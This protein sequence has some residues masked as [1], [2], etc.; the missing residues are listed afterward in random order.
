MTKILLIFLHARSDF[1]ALKQMVVAV[2]D[3]FELSANR[4]TTN[5]GAL[6]Y[7]Q[8]ECLV[9]KRAKTITTLT[10]GGQYMA[11]TYA[12]FYDVEY[13]VGQSKTNAST[14]VMLVQY[15]LFYGLVDPSW[16][17]PLGPWV[18]QS[19]GAGDIFPLDG[20]FKPG[21]EEWIKAF[22]TFANMNGLG[23]LFVDGFVSHGGAAWG[24]HKPKA[25]KWYT[26]HAMNHVLFLANK[27][28]FYNLAADP[29][30]PGTL[31]GA[32]NN[33]LVNTDAW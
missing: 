9:S 24:R 11:L 23:P 33:M 26:I 12:P 3:Y 32:L 21:L 2:C 20:V 8:G 5:E 31:R 6:L 7:L 22:Q 27:Q 10:E 17:V 1:A 30:V 16:N 18:P 25:Q 4:A 28:R 15:F 13:A 29:T 19:G 14:D